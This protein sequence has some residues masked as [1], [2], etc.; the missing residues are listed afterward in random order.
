MS[1]SGMTSQRDKGVYFFDL[2]RFI[3]CHL[4]ISSILAST[5]LAAN[6][7]CL[8]RLSVQPFHRALLAP[9]FVLRPLSL[10]SVFPLP[11]H[12]TSSS[13]SL[14][15]QS[16]RGPVQAADAE[17][18]VSAPSRTGAAGERPPGR[19]AH[20]WATNGIAGVFRFLSFQRL[21]FFF[22]LIKSFLRQQHRSTSAR[23]PP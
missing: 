14:G 10:H 19:L 5:A 9:W 23:T 18:P 6:L 11:F 12:F 13:S 22:T 21:F 4:V 7:L 16:A 17:G 8:P 1:R 15:L 2:P 3:L 20:R